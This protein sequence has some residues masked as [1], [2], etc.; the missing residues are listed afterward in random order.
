MQQFDEYINKVIGKLDM[1]K[2]KKEEMAD[3]F[4]DHL[5]MLKKDLLENGLT[6]EEAA[7]GAIRIFGDSRLLEL[8]LSK[9]SGGYRNV[10]NVIFGIAFTF[11][12]FFCSVKVPVPGLKSWDQIENMELFINVIYAVSAFILFIPLGYFIPV[13]FKKAGKVVYISVAALVLGP[14]MTMLTSTGFGEID[15]E[16]LLPYITGGLVGSLLGFSLLKWV[17]RVSGR[18]KQLKTAMR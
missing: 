6:G 18:L 2:E 7:A 3:E 5:N 4:R 10:S 12:L 13:I 15:T 11:L 17:N 8:H 9:S 16:L 14:V 1:G